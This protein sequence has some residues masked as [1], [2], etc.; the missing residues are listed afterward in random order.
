MLLREFFGNTLKVNDDDTPDK[1][2][3]NDVFWFILDHDKMH[4]DYAVPMISRIKKQ[5]NFSET[6]VIKNFM[7]LVNKGCKEFYMKNDMTGH[8]KKV[9]PKSLRMELCNQL[10]NHYCDSISN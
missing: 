6:D 3:S 10:Y 8:L 2:V 5:K 1:S 4:K 9:F 7:P